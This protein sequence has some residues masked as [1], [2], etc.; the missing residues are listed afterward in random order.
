[1]AAPAKSL[2]FNSLVKR[3]SSLSDELAS[4]G[5]TMRELRKKA[6]DLGDSILEFMKKHDIDEVQVDGAGK[7][8]RRTSKRTGS[9]TKDLI[10]SELRAHVG[11][12]K[13]PEVIERIMSRRET[14]ESTSLKR[15]KN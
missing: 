5:K 14:T 8:V 10:A 13:I 7:L 12:D 1:M 6:K 15:S 3:Y 2:E 4:S 11:E 9:L